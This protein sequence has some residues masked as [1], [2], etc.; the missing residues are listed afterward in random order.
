MTE[1]TVFDR[2]WGNLKWCKPMWFEVMSLHIRQVREVQTNE[3]QAREEVYGLKHY[4]KSTKN[5]V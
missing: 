3:D 1:L 4:L 2:G 5:S